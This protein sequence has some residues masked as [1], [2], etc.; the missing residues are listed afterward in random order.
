[1][2]YVGFIS[3]QL[4]LFVLVSNHLKITSEMD[5]MMLYLPCTSRPAGDALFIKTTVVVVETS[6]S[7]VCCYLVEHLL[8]P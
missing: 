1:M 4:S 5:G 3:G 2:L 7:F 6:V 8:K